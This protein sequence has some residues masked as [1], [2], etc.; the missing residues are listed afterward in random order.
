[1]G[2]LWFTVG[3]KAH[4]FVFAGID[5]E[6]GVVGEGGIEQAQGVGEVDFLL[7]LQSAAVAY[8]DAGGGPFAHPVQRQHDSLLE[9]GRVECAGGV[10]L[11]VFGE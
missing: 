8:A 3:G 7:H 2:V 4:H 10:A 5:L 6:S 9:W 1:M 11:V